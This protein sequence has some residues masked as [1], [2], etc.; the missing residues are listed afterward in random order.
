MSERNSTPYEFRGFDDW[1]EIFRAGL[2]TDS[3]GRE[4]LFTESDLDEMVA[5]HESGFSAPIVIGH[6]EQNDPAYGWSHEM[7][8]DGQSLYAKFKDIHP[9]F[10]ASVEAGNY[11]TRSVRVAKDKGRWLVDHVGFLGAKRP[12]IPLDPMNY[13]APEGEV[14]DFSVAA[15]SHGLLGGLFRR[16]REFFIAQF[17]QDTAD[18]VMPPWELDQLQQNAGRMEEEEREEERGLHPSFSA[19]QQGDV[20]MPHSEEDLQRAR[21]EARAE[22]KAEAQAEFAARESELE[23]DLATE[24]RQRQTAEFQSFV[25]QAVDDEHMTPAQAEGAAEFMASLAGIQEPMEFSAGEGD[26]AT[27]VKKPPLDWFREFVAALPKHGLTRELGGD[28]NAVD[29]NDAE[30]IA[31]AAAEFMAAEADAGR[32]ISVSQAVSHVTK[33]GVK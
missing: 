4:K 16:M 19:S 9:E 24:R 22:G 27:T 15:Y 2:Q 32:T 12:S 3:K 11:R 13:E 28:D 18:R 20:L 7:K 6:P 33:K 1:V 26:K 31:K 5:S 17:G 21:E 8:R 29:T 23:T 14:Y 30:A 25:S 10:A